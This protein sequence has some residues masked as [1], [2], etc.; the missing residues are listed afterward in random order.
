MV[1]QAGQVVPRLFFH[2]PNR[3]V[4]QKR[5]RQSVLYECHST[6]QILGLR[7]IGPEG[8]SSDALANPTRD[9][10]FD[11]RTDCLEFLQNNQ[12]QR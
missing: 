1:L 12:R 5:C 3:Q 8:L 7:K 9:C 2:H 10:F 6:A 11:A 4:A